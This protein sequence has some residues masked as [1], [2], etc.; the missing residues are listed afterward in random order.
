MMQKTWNKHWLS[1][2]NP[3]SVC[4]L[5]NFRGIGWT[6]PRIHE[7]IV[8]AAHR[9][10]FVASHKNNFT[11]WCQKSKCEENPN[12]NH[13]RIIVPLYSYAG[14]LKKI[15]HDIIAVDLLTVFAC[16]AIALRTWLS[17]LQSI[18]L[19][20]TTVWAASTPA[21]AA[22]NFENMIRSWSQVSFDGL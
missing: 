16:Y 6:R 21:A 7:Q 18:S 12:K 14:G 5:D 2:L 1:K 10:I 17:T 19:A 20:R 8:H 13:G 9:T 22:N 15:F 4:K 11:W 3:S